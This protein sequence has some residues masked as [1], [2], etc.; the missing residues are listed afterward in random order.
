MVWFCLCD[1]T[2]SRFSRTRTCDRHM[3]STADAQ[4][5]T[6]KPIWILLKQETKPLKHTQKTNLTQ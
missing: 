6:V 3:A 2:F 5:R 1:P 4:H